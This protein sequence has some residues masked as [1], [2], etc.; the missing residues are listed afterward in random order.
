MLPIEIHTHPLPGKK[1]FG[2][3]PSKEI[4]DAIHRLEIGQCFYLPYT[5]ETYN[6]ISTQASYAKR[7]TTK[8][9]TMRKLSKD[10]ENIIGLWRTN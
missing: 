2:T 9:F 4:A 1:T 8:K 6:M 5:K 10:T 7:N 3:S